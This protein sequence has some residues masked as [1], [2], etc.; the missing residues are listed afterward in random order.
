MVAER[1]EKDMGLDLKSYDIGKAKKILKGV[2][3]SEI[4]VRKEDNYENR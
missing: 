2:K 4:S 1:V 3:L